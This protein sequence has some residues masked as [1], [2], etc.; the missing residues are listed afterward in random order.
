MVVLLS[1]VK[2]QIL[3]SFDLVLNRPQNVLA[4][5]ILIRTGITA[6]GTAQGLREDAPDLA[7]R[8]FDLCGE[9]DARQF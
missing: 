6:P 7:T 2:S 9:R 8:V 3:S 4:N 5:E 1:D